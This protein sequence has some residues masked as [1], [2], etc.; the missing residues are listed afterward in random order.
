V[1]GMLKGLTPPRGKSTIAPSWM[2]E[3]CTHRQTAFVLDGADKIASRAL[4]PTSLY[5][6]MTRQEGKYSAASAR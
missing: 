6:R 4:F 2:R 1:R 3:L 5:R